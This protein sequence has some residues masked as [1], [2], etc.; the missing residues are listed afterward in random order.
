MKYIWYRE[1]TVG[2]TQRVGA[3]KATAAT[4]AVAAAVDRVDGTIIGE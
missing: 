4:P 1:A 2:H 3:T